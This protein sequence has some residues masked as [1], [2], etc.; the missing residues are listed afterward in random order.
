[1]VRPPLENKKNQ[2]RGR[3]LRRCNFLLSGSIDHAPRPSFDPCPPQR[4]TSLAHLSPSIAQSRPHCQRLSDC[5]S[6][7]PTIPPTWPLKS[8]PSLFLNP[9]FPSGCALHTHCA[10]APSLL[11]SADA[12][13]VSGCSVALAAS[14]FSAA[15][16]FASAAANATLRNLSVRLFSCS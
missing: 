12:L 13:A 16:L 11:F 7:F 6:V 3:R 8:Q 14:W 2:P 9:L 5:A 10:A 1:M 15:F 4:S